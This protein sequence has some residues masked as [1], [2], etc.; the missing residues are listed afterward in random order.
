MTF[1]SISIK[2]S[3]HHTRKKHR[4]RMNGYQNVDIVSNHN[5]V[6][7]I[8]ENHFWNRLR[9]VQTLHNRIDERH[10][11]GRS[12]SVGLISKSMFDCKRLL[13][14]YR[15]NR[16]FVRSSEPFLRNVPF[17]V[18]A[19]VE[20]NVHSENSKSKT[21]STIRIFVRSSYNPTIVRIFFGRLWKVHNF[22]RTIDKTIFRHRSFGYNFW[23]FLV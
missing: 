6:A 19:N 23:L 20:K 21:C 2:A 3:V 22:V 15:S 4:E 5:F 1:R 18:T 14:V 8:L 10:F 9:N 12:S 13:S 11:C 16:S 17:F 7:E